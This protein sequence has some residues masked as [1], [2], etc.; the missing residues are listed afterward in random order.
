M[1]WR[2]L[3]IRDIDSSPPEWLPNANEVEVDG[4]AP[5][6]S[7]LDRWCVCIGANEVDGACD[8]DAVAFWKLVLGPHGGDAAG[9]NDSAEAG[10][11]LVLALALVGEV[12]GNDGERRLEMRSSSVGLERLAGVDCER[13]EKVH[14]V[15]VAAGAVC[16]D[17]VAGWEGVKGDV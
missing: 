16:D 14:E 2:L 17:E 5:K 10:L 7:E 9:G 11:A 15:G 1:E 3:R 4:C 13:P 12:A 6:T 8:P